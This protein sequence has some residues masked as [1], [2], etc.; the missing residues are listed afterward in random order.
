MQSAQLRKIRDW[1][2]SYARAGRNDLPAAVALKLDH[3]RR[4][5]ENA[6]DIARDLGWS[7]EDIDLAEALG[8]LHDV[9]RFAQF[10]EFGHFHDASSFNHGHRGADLVRDSGPLVDLDEESR[11]TLLDGIRHH[12]AKTI[13]AGLPPDHV[14][15]LQLIR[16]ADKL[17]IFRVVAEG[18][19]RDGFLELADL[20]PHID[21]DGPI[22]PLLLQEIRSRKQGDI[23]H[24]KSLADFLL[25]EASWLYDLHWAPARAR[26][27]HAHVLDTLAARLPSDPD[28]CTVLDEIRRFLEKDSPC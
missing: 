27:R 23:T 21:L 24:V 1:V 10:N 6:R 17:D 5:A 14:R 2:E 11:A 28:V 20:W 18:L 7:P 19:V 22:N 15:F 4:V 8:W 3:T 16:D 12:N 9:G 26:A 13:P 25:L